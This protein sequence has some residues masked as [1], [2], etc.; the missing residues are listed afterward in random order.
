MSSGFGRWPQKP[1]ERWLG[2]QTGVGILPPG[3]CVSSRLLLQVRGTQSHWERVWTCFRV[4]S[5]KEQRNRDTYPLTAISHWWSPLPRGGRWQDLHFWHVQSTMHC[6]Q[7][8]HQWLDKALSRNVTVFTNGSQRSACSSL[9]AVHG[10]WMVP[11]QHLLQGHCRGNAERPESTCDWFQVNVCAQCAHMHTPTHT[12]TS[13]PPHTHPH[14]HTHAH[15][16]PAPG[17]SSW[18]S[19][20]Q[21]DAISRHALRCALGLRLLRCLTV[22]QRLSH[23]NYL[24]LGLIFCLKDTKLLVSPE[25]LD[26]VIEGRMPITCNFFTVIWSHSTLYIFHQHASHL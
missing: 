7:S 10:M 9:M 13:T 1:Q 20:R 22:C 17:Q 4:I 8:G 26:A 14:T 12:A 24:L 6:T 11:W 25:S 23:P 19:N 2:S 16:H 15:T 21:S 5:P 18:T 3:V